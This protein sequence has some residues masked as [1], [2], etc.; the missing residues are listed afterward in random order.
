MPLGQADSPRYKRELALEIVCPARF[1]GASGMVEAVPLLANQGVT[2]IEINLSDP[3]HIDPQDVDEVHKLM[4]ALSVSGVRVH[5]VHAPFGPDFDISSLDDAVHETGVDKLI[6][7]IELANVLGAGNVILHASHKIV[8]SVNGR[9][10]RARGVLRELSLV[11]RDTGLLLALENLPPGYVGHTP[12]EVFALL[13]G[14]EKT[15]VGVCFDTGHANLSGRFVEFARALLPRSVTV[16]VHDNDG[17]EDQ[18]R[19]PGAGS[20]DWAAFGND[21]R[22]CGCNASI[23]LECSPPQGTQWKEAFQQL[24]TAVGG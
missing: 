10:E 20:I 7:S 6:E 5:S 22:R 3:V 1:P 24:R 11:A 15:G 21:Y 4:I 14:C 13:D 23:M 17:T 9:F 18:H 19:F 8:G 16:H 2:E 12:D